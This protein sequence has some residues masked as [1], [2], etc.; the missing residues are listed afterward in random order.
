VI[1]YTGRH[2][3]HPLDTQQGQEAPS[4]EAIA[5]S[6]GRIPRFCGHTEHWYSVLSHTLVVAELVPADCK[7]HALLHDAPECVVNDVP[8]TWKTDGHRDNEHEVL[9]RIYAEQHLPQPTGSQVL[10]VKRADL[11]ALAAEAHILK[12]RAA[13]WYWPTTNSTEE[14]LARILTGAELARTGASPIEPHVA[15][16]RYLAAVNNARRPLTAAA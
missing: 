8:T 11:L 9:E 12:Q 1:D 13:E 7:I 4:L 2:I 6:L 15:K 10:A 16:I 3:F 5:V 14:R